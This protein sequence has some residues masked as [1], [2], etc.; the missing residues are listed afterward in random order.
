MY[1]RHKIVKK[2]LK[3]KALGHS[4]VNVS[5]FNSFNNEISVF[6]FDNR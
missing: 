5:F 4:P 6:V 3:Q 1:L 2:K